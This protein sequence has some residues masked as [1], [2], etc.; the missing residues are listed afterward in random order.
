MTNL[1]LVIFRSDSYANL[2]LAILPTGGWRNLN[3]TRMKVLKFGGTSVGTPDT[4]KGLLQI[5]KDYYLR[6]DRFAVVFSAFSKVTDTLIDLATRAGKGDAHYR[7]VFEKLRERHFAAIEQLLEPA[8]R[9][10]VEAEMAA[11]FEALGN[12]LQGIFLLH[13]VSP[14]S[15][16]FVVS[17]GERNSA[18]IVAHA[19]RQ[20]G[21]PTEFLDTRELIKTDAHF[22]SAKV[23]FE[24]SNRRITAY[25]S[26]HTKVQA[27]TGFIGSTPDNITTTLGRGGS[28]YT[29]AI[30]G[31]ALE[32]EAIEIWTDVDGVL[33][34]DPRRVKKAFTLTSMTYREAMEMS[35]FGAKVIYPPTILPALAK[36]IPLVIKNTFNPS[37]PGTFIGNTLARNSSSHLSPEERGAAMPGDATH[38]SGAG[39]RA[40]TGISS[41]NQV[42]LLTLQGSGLFGVPGIAARLFN[43][44]AQAGVNVVIITQGSSESSITFAVSPAHARLAQKAAEKEFSFEIREHLVEPLK[45]EDNLSVIAVVG[46]NMRY[47]PGVAGRLFQAL[48][49]NGVNIV[50]IAQGSSELNVS[51]VIGAQD[52]TKALN[53]IHEAF[54]LSDTKTLHLFLVG[55]GLIGSTLLDQIRAQAGFLKE[56]RNLEI[57]I[58]GLANSRKM[59]FAEDGI[60][61]NHWKVALQEGEHFS[62]PKFVEHM[63]AL[64][65]PNAIFIDNTA[66]GEIA[67]FYEQILDA[68]ISISTPN[69]VAAS[70]SYQQYHRLKQTAEKRGVLW[71]YETNVGAGLPLITTLSDLIHSGDRILKIEGVLSGTLSF[72]FNHFKAGTRFSEVVK[73]ARHLG[74]TEPDPR[75]DLSG[76]DVRRK[77]L[78]LARETGLPL[79]S[80]DIKLEN[81]LPHACLVVH[82]VEEFF[83]ELEKHDDHF[84]EMRLAAEKQGRVLR[85]VAK[86]EGGKTSITLT[87]FDQ[88]HPFYFLSGSDNMVVFT[89]ERYRERPLVIRG[90]GAGAEVTAAGVFAEVIGI[91]SYLS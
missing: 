29:A 47:R 13:E 32:A 53:A 33:T 43:A 48:G 34:A 9:P 26:A 35:H 63:R 66:S 84:E 17:F 81:I 41:I 46:E 22:G 19:M 69:K 64:N 40:I 60:D 77:L 75:E 23:D 30:L 28:D 12:V 6:G 52:E 68:S 55:V 49:K 76:A 54:F 4:I 90:P 65:L 70:S 58:A 88:N 85:M 31:A 5:L 78:I 21:I 38:P 15:L 61:L 25:F 82:S 86:L 91:G 1:W 16:D 20:A 89:T 7:D 18:F 83:E 62:M 56:K 2:R 57:R 67:G 24:E 10:P 50:A 73:E 80:N 79:E 11:N 71:R 59:A 42:C 3:K 37:F 51:M 39:M 36:D 44:L 87:A 8:N 45:I 27:A 72:I 14:R 74:L